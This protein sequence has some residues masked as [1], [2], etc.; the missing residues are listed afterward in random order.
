MK[1]LKILI[2]LILLI[3]TQAFAAK[4]PHT[5][6]QWAAARDQVASDL[7]AAGVS[8]AAA[9]S[10]NVPLALMAGTVTKYAAMYGIEGIKSVVHFLKG[11]PP[12]DLGEVNLAFI[13]MIQTK[14]ML[15]QAMLQIRDQAEKQ[16]MVDNESLKKMLTDVENAITASCKDSACKATS[17]DEKAVNR[18]LLNLT[19][20]SKSIPD[21]YK[22]LSIAQIQNSYHYLLLLYL[23][24]QSVEQELLQTLTLNLAGQL[25]KLKSLLKEH[26]ILSNAEKELQYQRA[27]GIVIQWQTQAD[28]RRVELGPIFQRTLQ[29][30]KEQN[31]KLG[32]ELSKIQGKSK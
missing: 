22:N 23:D 32:T 11:N 26:P 27:L 8:T 17:L 29:N 15:Y 13:Y 3:H 16:K 7:I 18:N 30:L 21:L 4:P 5:D 14:R 12:V 10:G 24:T 1:Q 25:V 6:P 20:E 9:L 19:L 28:E 2:L 31:Q